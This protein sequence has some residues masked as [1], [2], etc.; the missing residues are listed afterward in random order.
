MIA[1]WEPK[2][3]NCIV[4]EN[5]LFSSKAIIRVVFRKHITKIH[6]GEI[7]QRLNNHHSLMFLAINLSHP[8]A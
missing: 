5:V 1:L 7:I 8:S 2:E 6:R 4:F 3:E